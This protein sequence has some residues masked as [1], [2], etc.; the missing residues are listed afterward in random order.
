[1]FYVIGGSN[2]DIYCKSYNELIMK[3]SNPSKISFSFGGVAR[4]ICVNLSNLTSDVCLVT[5]FGND[6]FA[7]LIKDDLKE[8]GININYSVNSR[9]DSSSIYM[10]ILNIDD[11]LLGMNDMSVI[12]RID[13]S[14]IDR[15]EDIVNED[16]YVVLDTNLSKEM[17]EYILT[18]LKGA[19][20]CDSISA[21]KVGK[22]EGI[23]DNI[24]ILKMNLL[25]ASTLAHKDLK[26]SNDIKDFLATISKQGNNEVLITQKDCV[27]IGEN[28]K[29]YMYQ[30]NAYNNMPVNVTGAGDALISVYAFSRS[31]NK[32]I[33]DSIF[34]ALA[35]SIKTVEVNDPVYK[36]DLTLLEK[37]VKEI[38]I[39]KE[40]L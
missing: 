29:V 28:G 12:D 15:L 31:K 35:A 17:I 39:K 4:N 40:I 36:Y 34:L 23:T 2:I 10:A 38:E 33:D 24:N 3:D 16:D 18:N 37:L 7:K 22:L 13:K 27:Y 14:A 19:K 1:M 8:K 6:Y 25:E 11:M 9:E 20:V 21:N 32:S 5:A 26:T 30:H